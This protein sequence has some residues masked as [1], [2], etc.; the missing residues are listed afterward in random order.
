MSKPRLIKLPTFK[1]KRG[2]LTVWDRGEDIPFEPK[3]LFWIY[4]VYPNET[5]AN[6]G[7]KE[8]EQAIFAVRGSFIVRC[9]NKTFVLFKPALGVYIPAG[10]NIK[11]DTFSLDAVCLVVA[12]HHYD[13]DK[14]INGEQ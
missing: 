4:S 1:D 13:E 11:L 3:R 6:H 2:F 12:S 5:R 9:D 14:I 10:I 7:H 8:C